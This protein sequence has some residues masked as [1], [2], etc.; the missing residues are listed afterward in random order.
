MKGWKG[1]PE[2]PSESSLARSAWKA[3]K[4]GPSRRDLV[5]VAWHEVPGKRERA[6]R[7]VGT[8]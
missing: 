8:Q 6:D 4:C 7:P 3:G 1:V 5:K 2:G